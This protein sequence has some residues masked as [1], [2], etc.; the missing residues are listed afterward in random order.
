MI[1]LIKVVVIGSGKLGQ[2]HLDNWTKMPGVEVVGVIARNKERLEK[3]ASKYNT[4]AFTSIQE[5]LN[6]YRSRCI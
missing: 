6:Q 1:L 2:R 3:V 5:V 4:K